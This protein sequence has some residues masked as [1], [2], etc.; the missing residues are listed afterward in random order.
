[1]PKIVVTPQYIQGYTRVTD[2]GIQQV[3]GHFENRKERRGA[4]ECAPKVEYR[5]QL[6]IIDSALLIVKDDAKRQ[7]LTAKRAEIAKALK[8]FLELHPSCRSAAAVGPAAGQ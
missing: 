6:A 5:R 3:K 8:D 2:K 1:M 4:N 7:A